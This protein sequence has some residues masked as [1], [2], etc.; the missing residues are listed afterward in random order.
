MDLCSASYLLCD[1][2]QVTEPLRLPFSY[3]YNMDGEACPMKI[4]VYV[5]IWTHIY[6]II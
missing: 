6:Y 5:F 4:L 3:V 1:H 2:E